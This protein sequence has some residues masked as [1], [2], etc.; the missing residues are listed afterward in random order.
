MREKLNNNP[1]AQVGLVVVLIVVVGFMLVGGGL[2]GGEE[3]E[4]A[5]TTEAT[6]SVAG[7]GATGT[8]TGA[9]PGEAVEGAVEG[10]L[11]AAPAA[12][13]SASVASSIPPPPLPAPVTKAY[14]A[15]KTVILLVVHDG[16]IDD[17][18][19]AA[20]TKRLSPAA[21][22][23][24]FVAPVKQIVRY[25]AITLGVDLQQ[26][27]ALVVM[28]PRKLSDGTPQASVSYGFQSAQSIEQAVRDASYRGPEATYHPD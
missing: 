11:E 19:V 14:N 7:T 13:S 24:L 2:G 15:G 25:G 21:D 16:G 6:V 26:V 23:A 22:V 8:A 9:T 4:E 18:L 10:A 12:A 17:R 27:P 1:M 28:R 5:P 3:S 20:S